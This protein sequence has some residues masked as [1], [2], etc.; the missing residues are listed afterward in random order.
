MIAKPS[1]SQ[2]DKAGRQRH[3]PPSDKKIRELELAGGKAAWKRGARAARASRTP[4]E[5]RLKK[6]GRRADPR[7]TF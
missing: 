3:K 6:I 5:A 1:G 2:G 4:S 7:G